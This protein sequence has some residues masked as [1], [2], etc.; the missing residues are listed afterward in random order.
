VS[1]TRQIYRSVAQQVT[2]HPSG[3]ECGEV[4]EPTKLSTT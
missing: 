3:K 1:V 2:G 4:G